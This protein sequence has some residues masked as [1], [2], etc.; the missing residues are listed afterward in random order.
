[1]F[2]FVLYNYFMSEQLS[3]LTL[4]VDRA[5]HPYDSGP[6][7]AQRVVGYV[8]DV[9]SPVIIPDYE[10]RG[11]RLEVTQEM[12]TKVAQRTR[13]YFNV[14]CLPEDGRY[15]NCLAYA[16]YAGC[17][18]DDMRMAFPLPSPRLIEERVEPNQLVIGAAYYIRTWATEH[19]VVGL[20]PG[21]NI[22]VPCEGS[23]RA[24]LIKTANHDML[25][26]YGPNATYYKVT[27]K[28]DQ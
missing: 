1:M 22:C 21:E 11:D 17:L 27:P 4:I 10:F 28:A 19:A 20:G 6:I 2:T 18:T 8:P 3:G 15:T 5:P 7:S 24:P 12:P 26:V 14:H 16:N 23:G 25:S 9:G 13:N